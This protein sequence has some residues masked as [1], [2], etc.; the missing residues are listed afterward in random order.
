MSNTEKQVAPE[1]AT[2]YEQ[3]VELKE[4]VRSLE[5]DAESARKGRLA[6]AVRVRKA[7]AQ[8]T[9]EIKE[10]RVLSVA[11]SKAEH[12]RR[13]ADRAER[14]VQPRVPPRKKSV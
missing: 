10:L 11:A 6:A 12:A 14:G 3:F 4:L 7:L 13:A 1:L 9:A 2:A 8:L 5:K